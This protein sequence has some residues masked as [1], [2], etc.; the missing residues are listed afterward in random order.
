M[1]TRC[2]AQIG[3][4]FLGVVACSNASAVLIQ[5]NYWGADGFR[6][7]SDRDVIGEKRYDIDSME[8]T[9][10]NLYMK[11]VVNTN[12]INSAANPDP[13]GV[14]Y[15]DLFISTNGWNPKTSGTHYS[16]DNIFTGEKWEFVFD[17]DTGMLHGG[18]FSINTSNHFFGSTN[19]YYRKN[20]EVQYASGGTSLNDSSSIDLLNVGDGGYIEYNILLS[21]LGLTSD[22]DIGFKW[23]M[24][25]A[26]DTIEGV[27]HYTS[28]PE[29]A[30]VLMFGLGLLGLGMSARKKNSN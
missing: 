3:L 21:S 4:G 22:T 1:K 11:V 15:G 12:F 25:C 28:V 29:P 24:T 10:D 14:N 16:N 5:D 13:Y 9:F 23:G 6:R 30:T 19:Y 27:V 8:V 26:N 17:T 7:L 20:Q 18:D 2:L